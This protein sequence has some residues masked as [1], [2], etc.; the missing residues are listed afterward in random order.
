[1]S[2]AGGNNVIYINGQ[3]Y[4]DPEWDNY[5]GPRSKGSKSTVKIEEILETELENELANGFHDAMGILKDGR[6]G[7]Q[8]DKYVGPKSYPAQS[9]QKNT[10]KPTEYNMDYLINEFDNEPVA[11]KKPVDIIDESKIV[12]EIN[13]ESELNKAEVVEVTKEYNDPC[14]FMAIADAFNEIKN[15]GGYKDVEADKLLEKIIY[16]ANM[17]IYNK[18]KTKYKDIPNMGDVKEL[19]KYIETNVCL[20][21]FYLLNKI[22]PL[23]TFVIYIGEDNVTIGKENNVFCIRLFVNSSGYHLVDVCS[24][25]KCVK[26]NQGVSFG[27]KRVK[28]NEKSKR[29][30]KARKRSKK[31][32]KT[33]KTSKRPRK[34]RKTSKTHKRSKNK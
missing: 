11:Q 10:V 13:Q 15:M 26:Y 8:L 32:R 21:T 1:M 6:T 4:W 24:I 3:G 2:G 7:V 33:R 27:S 29:S 28:R 5:N 12:E 34:A 16:L 31:H 22:Y 30:R 14:D 18:Y 20:L 9:V 17:D 19:R 25:N 23:V